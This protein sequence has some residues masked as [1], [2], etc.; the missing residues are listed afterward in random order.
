MSSRRDPAVV[1]II[2]LLGAE[3]LSQFIPNSAQP[4]AFIS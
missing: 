2:F 1:F 4:K 3:T